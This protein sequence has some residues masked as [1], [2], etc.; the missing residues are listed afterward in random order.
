MRERNVIESVFFAYAI[1]N[2]SLT[3]SFSHR[4]QVEKQMADY[5]GL[6]EALERY[7]KPLGYL[8]AEFFF[9]A[10]CHT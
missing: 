4:T 8:N 3:M 9:A 7:V 1:P 5:I 10:A 2:Q 6:G